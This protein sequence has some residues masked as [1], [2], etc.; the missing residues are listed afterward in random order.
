[1]KRHNL[2]RIVIVLGIFAA[3]ML[4]LA[5]PA[6][7]DLKLCNTTTSR[8]GVAIGYK[9]EKGWVSEGWWNVASQTCEVLLKGSLVARYYYIHAVDYDRGGE[10]GGPSFMCTADK[11]FTIRG[12]DDCQS[13]GN[14][15]SGFFEV[16]TNEERDW[17][18]RLTDPGDNG[19]ATQ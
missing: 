7:A 2:G 1:M 8:V 4:G 5:A 13:R 15:R 16:D 17:T 10:W 19:T 18:V 9:D 6:R 3:A 12:V 11:A 14:K